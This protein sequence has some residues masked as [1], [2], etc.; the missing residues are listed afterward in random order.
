MIT[1]FEV[2]SIYRIFS[3]NLDVAIYAGNNQFI[4]IREKFGSRYLDSEFYEETVREVAEQLGEIYDK[5]IRLTE[6]LP[7]S[8]CGYCGANTKFNDNLKKQEHIVETDCTEV[9]SFSKSN[10][11]LFQELDEYGRFKED[12]SSD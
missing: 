6:A 3:R 1:K 12:I 8:S 4:G 9:N 7:F 2:G 11:L 10:F 5:N